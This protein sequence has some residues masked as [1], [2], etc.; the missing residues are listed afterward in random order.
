MVWQLASL[1]ESDWKGQEENH[2]IFYDLDLEIIFYLFCNTQVSYVQQW[3]SLVAQLVKNLP[4]MQEIPVQFLVRK[5][6]WRR[7]R[8]PTPVSWDFP[9]GSGGKEST[10]NA[11]TWVQSLAWEDPLENGKATHSSILAWR[12]SWTIKSKGSQR[13][14]HDWATFTDISGPC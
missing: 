14:R 8:L 2:N 12:I 5:I 11:D 9:C 13:V 6:C 1:R 7:D 4:A 10:C 3:D